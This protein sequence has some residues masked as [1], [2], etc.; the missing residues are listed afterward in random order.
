[1]LASPAVAVTFASKMFGVMAWIMPIFVGLSV[2]GG[3]NG[4]LFTS[5]SKTLLR[6]CSRGPSTDN[7]WNDSL[8][9][10]YTNAITY[11]Y[12]CAFC[13]DVDN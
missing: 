11:I 3:V 5:S 1:M 12:V 9:E 4:V 13:G 10:V 8:Q 6:W 7:I 2:F